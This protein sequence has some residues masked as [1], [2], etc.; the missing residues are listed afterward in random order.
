MFE[1]EEIEKRSRKGRIPI[2]EMKA[3]GSCEIGYVN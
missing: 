3:M 2:V 1:R